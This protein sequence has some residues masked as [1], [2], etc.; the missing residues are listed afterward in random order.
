MALRAARDSLPEYAHRK[1]PKKFTQPQLLAALVIKEFLQL[2]Y[3]GLHVLL[4]EWSDLRRTLGL[5]KVPHF[6]TLCAAAHRLLG[7]TKGYR[8]GDSAASL[9]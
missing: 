9:P 8:F 7:K 1:S 5:K 3:R 6:T 2:D 4:M